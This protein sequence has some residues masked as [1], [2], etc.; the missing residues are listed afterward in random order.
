MKESLIRIHLLEKTG[1]GSYNLHHTEGRYLPSSLYA[2]VLFKRLDQEVKR[3][4][5]MY[6]FNFTVGDVYNYS[7]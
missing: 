1:S 5:L 2:E 3:K 4:I 7:K 6:F